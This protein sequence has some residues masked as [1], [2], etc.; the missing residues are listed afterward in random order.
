MQVT[1]WLK[2]RDASL[3]NLVG[4]REEH[5]RDRQPESAGGVQ[6]DHCL[7]FRRLFDGQI[8]GLGAFENPVNI[9][10]G[11]AEQ[12]IVVRRIGNETTRLGVE[13]CRNLG[14]GEIKRRTVGVRS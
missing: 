12:V 7:E 13:V 6:V 8:S 14:D 9:E 10:G 3:D 4:A 11:A 5:G 1:G 2:N